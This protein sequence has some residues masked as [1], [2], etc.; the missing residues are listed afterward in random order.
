[1]SNESPFVSWE[2]VAQTEGPTY[3]LT[4]VQIRFDV[5]NQRLPGTIDHRSRIV[6]RRAE[7]NEFLRGDWQPT[8]QRPKP[9]IVSLQSK[10]S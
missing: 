8:A 7:W 1:M 10:A 6:I 9:G 3:G 4:K 2:E 5:K